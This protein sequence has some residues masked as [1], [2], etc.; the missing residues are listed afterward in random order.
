LALS[1]VTGRPVAIE[2]I[3]AGRDKPG[4][5]RQHLTAVRAAA[6][7]GSA[8][9]EGDK[10]GSCELKFQPQTIRPGNYKFAV[11]TAGSAT[12]VLQTVLPALIVADGPSTLTLEG[13][14]HNPWAPPFDFLAKAFFPLVNR[15]GPRVTA[16]LD[17]HGFYPAGGG[18][19]TIEIEPCKRLDGF[20]LLERGADVRRGVTA[21]V[22]Q[23]PRGIAQRELDAIESK[24]HWPPNSFRVDEVA[25]SAGPGNA[26][27]IE[28]VSEH[29]TEV[30]TAFGRYGVKSEHVGEE[31]LKQARDY[32][33]AEVPVGRY[34]ADQILLPLGIAVSQ[35]GPR[36]QFRTMPLSRHATTHVEILRQFLG[37][38]ISAE[39]SAASCLVTVEAD[40]D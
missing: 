31:A 18:K 19:F 5:M 10:I 35:G 34:L 21:V 1:L 13:G 2:N 4:L 23:L 32:L 14:T 28:I 6:E 22:A 36:R 3:R 9:L 27:M 24:T 11:G 20:D 38:H 26:V 30:F 15:M 37:I 8:L 12:L 16:Q 29:V 7:I 17:R 33:A 40:T 25:D 39:K